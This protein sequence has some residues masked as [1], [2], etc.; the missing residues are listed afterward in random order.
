MVC[1]CLPG[2]KGG[3]MPCQFLA[4]GALSSGEVYPALATECRL[5]R[6]LGSYPTRSFLVRNSPY[7]TIAVR[8]TIDSPRTFSF[9]SR[10]A[11]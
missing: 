1:G 8:S 6:G 10:S 4:R 3:L 9:P 11:L 2:T 7:E 5:W